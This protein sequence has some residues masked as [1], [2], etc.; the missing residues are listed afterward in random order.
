MPL[1][2]STCSVGKKRFGCSFSAR[3][4]SSFCGSVGTQRI[5]H[6]SISSTVTSSGSRPLPHSYGTPLNMY[7]TG[8]VLSFDALSLVCWRMKS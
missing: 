1:L 6:L 5:P 7:S 4:P 8:K 3:R 2:G